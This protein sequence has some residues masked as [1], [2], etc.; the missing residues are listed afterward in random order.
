MVSR[1]KWF[2]G[3]AILA[4]IVVAGGVGYARSGSGGSSKKKDLIILN[5]VQRR[6]LQDTVTLQGHA[7]A[8]RSCAR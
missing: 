6:T 1:N 7:R 4:L 2:V 8:P 5:D 3:I